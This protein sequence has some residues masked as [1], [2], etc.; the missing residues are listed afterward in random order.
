MPQQDT[1]TQVVV[2]DDAP[3]AQPLVRLLNKKQVLQIVKVTWPTL[4]KMIRALKFPQPVDIN[5]RPYWREDDLS[6][7]QN[8]LPRRVYKG[9]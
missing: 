8:S 2:E 9:M 4:W 1:I 3:R 6:E 5:G 7:W